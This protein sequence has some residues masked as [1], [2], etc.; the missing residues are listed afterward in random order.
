MTLNPLLAQQFAGFRYGLPSLPSD[1]TSKG[2][3]NMG[4][5]SRFADI[6]GAN[7]SLFPKRTISS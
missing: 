7:T 3:T 1:R 6:M 2:Q 5:L 4:M